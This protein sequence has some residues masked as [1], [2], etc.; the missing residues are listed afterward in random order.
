M[1]IPVIEN[2][3]AT[4]NH[5]DAINLSDNDISRLT[6]MCASLAA[7]VDGV[8]DVCS[9]DCTGNTAGA[10]PTCELRL[11]LRSME[12]STYA[13]VRWVVLGIGAPLFH[14]LRSACRPRS[15]TL[16]PKCDQ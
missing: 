9:V 1:K 14:I 16:P 2:L 7:A 4:Q 8:F 6:N 13:Y 10:T 11:Q 12:V 5:F 3:G 15:E